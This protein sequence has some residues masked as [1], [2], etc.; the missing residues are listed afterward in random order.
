[1]ILRVLH[2]TTRSY[3]LTS[4][5]GYIF[6]VLDERMS[7]AWQKPSL[8]ILVRL[9]SIIL[10]NLKALEPDT[11]YSTRVTAVNKPASL[12]RSIVGSITF[13]LVAMSGSGN[14]WKKPS[15]LNM[16]SYILTLTER[17]VMIG[18]SIIQLSMVSPSLLGRTGQP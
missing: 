8:G 6:S 2:G 18:R 7:T 4:G 10:D 17:F 11:V 1:M 15:R 14:C 16:L 13:Y 3:L 5:C 9:M 12:T